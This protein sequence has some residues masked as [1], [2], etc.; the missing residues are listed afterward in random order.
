MSLW[1]SL[2]PASVTVD[3]G[4]S[5]RVRLRVRNTGDVVDEYRFEPVGDVAPW[6][7]VE[8]PTLRLY[9]GTTGTV[10]LTFAPP[11]TPDAVAGPNPY[12][13]RILPTEHPDAVTVPEGNLT[14]TAFTEVRAELVPPTVK[15]RFRGR[16][17]LAV[18]NLGN[19][20]VT[21]SVA[22]SDHGDHLSYEVRPGNVQIEP[23]RAAFVETTLKPKQ[24]IW[25][26]AKEERPYTLAVRRSGVDPTE[27]EGTYVQRGFL[28]RWL[29]TFFGIFLALA[30]AFVMIWIAYKPQVRTSA[31][32]QTEQAGAAL[33]PSPSA[34]PE[35]L[36]S[37]AESEPAT[38]PEQPASEKPEN[39]G[40]AGGGDGGGGG[41]G[42]QADKPAKKPDVVPAMNVML[43]NATTHMCADIPGRE[44]GKV[45]GIVQQANCHEEGDN[46][47]WNLEV[48]YENGGPNGV[49]LFQIRNVTDQ[50]C[51]DLGEYGA[52]PEGTGIAEFHCDGTKADNQLWWI[53]KQAS[54]NYWI[55]NFASAH[56]C[57][58]V[59]GQN[60]GTETP[61]NIA[62][63]TNTDDQEWQIIRPSKD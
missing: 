46:E 22:G 52:R 55:R 11:R 17:R 30:I 61:L 14:I 49:K 58:N 54:G 35:A 13:V 53:D 32:E 7:T 25:F 10:E 62:T 39:D 56:K 40:G 34:T 47:Y 3:P 5:T 19:T 41:G 50:L 44:K 59:K 48:K 33:M 20:K 45:N 29:A 8:P 4:S 31:T 28:P 36:P 43:R 23:G 16:P 37:S 12:A 6:T 27:I 15:G 42:G 9:P 24:I 2:E 21:A 63:C 1:T 26:G 38:E 57:L 60:G 18:D 51:M